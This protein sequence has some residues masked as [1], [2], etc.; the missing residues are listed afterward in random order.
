MDKNL[1]D[2]QISEA[3][4]VLSKLK[5][6]FL[7]SPIFA[8]VARLSALPVIEIVPLRRN[9]VKVEVLLLNRGPQDPIF[10]NQLH[11]PGTIVRAT[12]SEQT[13]IDRLTQKELHG[14]SMTVPVFVTY[15]LH[16]SKRGTESARVFWVEVRGVPDIGQF[17]DSADLPDN[18]VE[19]QFDF[20]Q[21]AVEAYKTT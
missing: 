2:S 21:A 7:P 19:S 13:A 14:L 9:G 10:A 16:Q 4:Q 6:G 1:L 17:Y 20:I 12:D 3:A 11:T 8:E 18:L 5:P 15:T